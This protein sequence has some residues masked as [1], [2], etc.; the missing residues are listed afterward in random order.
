MGGGLLLMDRG[1]DTRVPRA[2]QLRRAMTAPER[3][4]WWRLRE[5]APNGSH[6]RRQA[7]IGPFFADF[8]YHTTKL[9]IEIDG[10]QHDQAGQFK[11]D[12]RRDAYLRRNG[13]RVLR[14]WNNDVR[15]NME[16]VLSVIYEVLKSRQSP[17]PPTPPHR[18]QG[19]G[20]SGAPPPGNG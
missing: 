14:F 20:R 7:T 6:F 2:R 5:L 19:E 10:G 9:V 13:C 15:E 11:R 1:R 17:P 3:K 18:K 12:L 8:A 16:G 4:L